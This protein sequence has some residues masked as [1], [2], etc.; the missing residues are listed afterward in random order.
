MIGLMSRWFA[1]PA[2]LALVGGY[3]YLCPSCF[4][5]LIQPHQDELLDVLREH[6]PAPRP[7]AHP[8]QPDPPAGTPPAAPGPAKAPA[9]P[10]QGL[11]GE[12]SAAPQQ[13]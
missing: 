3:F 11:A 2:G 8:D 1:A 5:E 6:H 9:A 4:E 12:P 13:E 10:D 7:T